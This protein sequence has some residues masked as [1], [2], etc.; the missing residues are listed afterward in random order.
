MPKIAP[1]RGSLSERSASGSRRTP[2]SPWI[3]G[4]QPV[5]RDHVRIDHRG[6]TVPQG[7]FDRSILPVG[8]RFTV[9]LVLWSE[10]PLGDRLEQVLGLFDTPSVRAGGATRRGLG[11]LKLARAAMVTFD[12]R[13]ADDRARF[14]QLPRE[15]Q[16]TPAV[17]IADGD[18]SRMHERCRPPMPRLGTAGSRSSLNSKISGGSGKGANPGG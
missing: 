7:K 4:G 18:G 15:V 12:L 6:I 13:N 8:N 1:S 11:R 3:D 17:L 9:E 2:C 14:A 5:A 16:A 10:T